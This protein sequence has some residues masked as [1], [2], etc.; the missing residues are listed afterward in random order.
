MILI[1]LSDIA[2]T[3]LRQRPHHL[4]LALAK[5]WRIL[6]VEPITLGSRIRLLP[7]EVEPNI[8]VVSIPEIP[9]NARQRIVR[10]TVQSLSKIGILRRLLTTV[11]VYL[12]RRALHSMGEEH[13][14]RAVIA[15]SFTLIDILPRL[16]P[17]YTLFDYIDNVLGFTTFPP[18]VQ[19]QWVHMLQRADAVTVSSLALARQVEPIRSSNVH[20]VGNGVE[21]E[22]FAVTTDLPRPRDLPAGAPVVMYAGAVY[23]WLDYELLEQ[24]CS[25]SADLNFVLVGPVHPEVADRI[26]ALVGP[27]NV[28]VLGLKPYASVPAYLHHADVCI[29]PF[30]KNELTKYVNPVKLY[31]YCAAGKPCV[32]TD[33]SEDVLA[34]RDLIVVA[35]SR[36]EFLRGI[37]ESLEQS[38]DSARQSA[39]RSFARQHDWSRKTSAI[40]EILRPHIVA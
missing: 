16:D 40:I 6:W 7:E 8:A 5:Q 14:R 19:V 35:T 4:A 24:V 31:E 10:S 26:Q 17:V 34:A 25:E 21:Y 9:Y 1:L 27:G 37:R 22:R 39:R 12:L 18:H 23:P 13:G 15:Y 11:Q 36:E 33:F 20:V 30:Q 32:V 28:H 2:W 3:G 38:K 29:I